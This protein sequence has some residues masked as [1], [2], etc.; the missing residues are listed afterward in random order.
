MH[1]RSLSPTRNAQKRLLGS[2]KNLGFSKAFMDREAS[3]ETLLQ[4]FD[5]LAFFSKKKWWFWLMY[6]IFYT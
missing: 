2:A 6:Y 3:S 1:H 5:H 4:T